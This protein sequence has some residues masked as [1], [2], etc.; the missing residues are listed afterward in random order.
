MEFVDRLLEQLLSVRGV[1]DPDD[2]AMAQEDI[3]QLIAASRERFLALPMLL[4]VSP[5]IKICGDVHGQYNDL[6]RMFDYGQLPP[7]SSYLFLGDYVDRGKQSLETIC[8]LLCL[9]LKHPDHCHV[10][11]GNHETASISRLYGFF[12]E[13]KRRYSTKLWKRFIDLFNC[14][15]V[16]ALVGGKILC[17]HGGLSPQ[18]KSLDDINRIPRPTDIPD[19]GLLC[20][21][22]WADPEPEQLGWGENDRGVSYT[23]GADVVTRFLAEH[24][25]DLICRAHQVM[26]AGYEF[27]ARRQLVTVFSAPNY[28]GEFDNSGAMMEVS[29]DLVCSFKVLR[30]DVATR[31]A[32]AGWGA[33]DDGVDD[34][35][36]AYG[37]VDGGAGYRP[38]T[39]PRP[40]AASRTGGAAAEGALPLPGEGI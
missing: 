5:P 38:P 30:P 2:V 33:E 26:D 15:P 35:A 25:L 28:C 18:L 40:A 27:F 10:L 7:L 14:M 19:A 6:L 20:D 13:C 11:R 17:M 24:N 4:E 9:S 31:A 32:G 23:F 12:D 34:P 16:A 3:M 22:L 8:L 39:P 1:R 21:I 29:T 36:A 37:G